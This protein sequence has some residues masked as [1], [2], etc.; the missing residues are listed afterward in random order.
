MM[1][2]QTK[3]IRYLQKAPPF[4]LP[5]FDGS[6]YAQHH[7]TGHTNLVVFFLRSASSSRDI[8]LLRE[9][10]A[11]VHLAPR[12]QA[13]FLALLPDPPYRLK[14]LHSELGLQFAL[15]SDTESRTAEQYGL[16]DGFLFFKK[17]RRTVLVQDKYSVMY[18]IA[19][20]ER[21]DEAPDWAAIEETLSKLPRR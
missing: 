17:L 2:D 6:I 5:G 9:I 14:E 21:D 1:R 19:V 15:V 16:F 8:E 11:H 20:A 12:H 18:H 4:K 10:N 7:Y 3:K 13:V